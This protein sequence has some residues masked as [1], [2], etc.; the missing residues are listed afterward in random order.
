MDRNL[1]LELVRVTEAAA[2][3]SA[4]WMGKGDGLEADNAACEAMALAIKSVKIHGTI[5]IG[6][7]KPNTP[8]SKGRVVGAGGPPEVDVALDPLESIDSVALGHPNAMSMIAVVERGAF[9]SSPVPYMNKIAVGPEAAGCIDIRSSPLENLV[10]IADAKRCYVEDITVCILDRERHKKLIDL[11]RE[12]GARI[13]LI[14]DGDIAG[15]IATAVPESG[16]DV[17]MGI[18]GANEGVLAAAALKCVGG[19]FQGQL[20]ISNDEEAAALKTVG[21][22]RRDKVL[23]LSDLIRG[24][25]TMFAATGV[26]N[27]DILQGVQFNPHGATTHSIVMRSK[28]GTIRFIKANHF[29]DKKPDYE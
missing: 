14:S 18:G 7:K 13:Q 12:A 4:R 15:A 25:N 26:T 3:A 21:F 29:F 22:G 1:A 19:D 27:S 6:E 5:V 24:D 9:F 2:L 23:K 10:N 20:H 28:S 11:V 17:L 16:V 8:L